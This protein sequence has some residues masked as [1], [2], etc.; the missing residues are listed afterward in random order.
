MRVTVAEGPHQRVNGGI[1]YGTE[2]RA[3]I[4]GEYRHLN[5][6]GGAR[7]F[8]AHAR[9]SSLDRGIRLDF[10]QPY[11][12]T[13]ALAFRAEGQQWYG[14]TPAYNSV[15]RGGRL[16]LKHQ[17]SKGLSFTLAFTSERNISTIATAVLN[18]PKLYTDLIAV[19]LDPTT[20]SQRGTLGAVSLDFQFVRT[21]RPLNPNR[22]YQFSVQV[23]EAGRL[24]PGTFN[25]NSLTADARAYVPIGRRIVVA[26]RVQFGDMRPAGG[27]PRQ[28]PFSRRY[29]LGGAT[30]L[31][32]W[33][34][35]EVS[36]LGA[37]GLP[38]G[39]NAMAA[40]SSELRT[41]LKGSLG[42]VLFIDSGN[43]WRQNVDIADLRL[44]VGAGL[45]YTT[46]VGPIRFDFGYQ[47]TPIEGL[48][49]NGAPEARRWRIHFSIGQAF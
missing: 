25:Y 37:S 21:D 30:S 24:L 11:V 1:G 47:L 43:V 13:S 44:S 33:G 6:L 39:G 36:P 19:G 3:R 27:D 42:G 38:I 14:Y 40:A 23:E 16:S 4:D 34:R 15:V 35:Y 45:R 8:G 49:V 48:L 29:F 31:R 28:V 20:S 41:P 17:R 7:S 9:Y 5:F 22:G 2:E 46:P 12:F 32:G 26:N 18:D 10:T